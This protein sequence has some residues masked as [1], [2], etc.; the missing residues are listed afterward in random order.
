MTAVAPRHLGGLIPVPLDAPKIH[1]HSSPVA[2]PAEHENTKSLQLQCPDAS[3]S[4]C[5]R[6]P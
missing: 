2:S 3:K 1:A 6:A 4:V 5:T